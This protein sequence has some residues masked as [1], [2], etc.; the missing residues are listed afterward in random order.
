[1]SKIVDFFDECWTEACRQGMDADC[2]WAATA[3]DVD[4]IERELGRR[5]TV[6]DWAEVRGR[7][8]RDGEVL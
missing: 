4:W 8:E 1:M 5:L 6:D 2:E 7:Y 3:L